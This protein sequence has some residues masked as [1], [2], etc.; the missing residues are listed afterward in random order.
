MSLTN[1]AARLNGFRDGTEMLTQPYESDNFVREMTETLEELT[2]LYQ[3][4][5]AYVRYRLRKV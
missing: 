1:E 5:H 2:P 4:L 3:Q